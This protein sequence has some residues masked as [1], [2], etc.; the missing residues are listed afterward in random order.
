MLVSW[1]I[2]GLRSALQKGLIEVLRSRKY[3]A[4]LLQEVKADVVPLELLAFGYN[5]YIYPAK[6]RGYSGTL[7][8]VKRKPLS[9]SMGI[10]VKEFDEEGRVITLEY[11]EFYLVNAYFP[12]SQRGLTRLGYKLRFNAAFE[13]YTQKL[14][15]RKPVVVGGDFNVAHTELDIARPKDNLNSAGFTKQERDWMTHFLSLGFIDTFRL[16][17]SGGGHYT[18]WTYRFS[19]RERNIGWRIDYFIVSEELRNKVVKAGILE[20]IKGSDHAPV[21]LELA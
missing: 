10:G 18:W 2:N 1:N 9:V 13:G 21:F 20:D 8:L 11:P 16:F 19:A 5:C 3:D 14:R 12:N 6:R 4:V 15:E 7:S 17:V